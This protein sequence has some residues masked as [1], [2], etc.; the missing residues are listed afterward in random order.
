[1]NVKYSLLIHQDLTNGLLRK[2]IHFI[3]GN[4][5]I[6]L[7][8]TLWISIIRTALISIDNQIYVY[9]GYDINSQ[10]SYLK[11]VALFE[12]DEWSKLPDLIQ[13]RRG[14]NA[15]PFDSDILVV[16]GEGTMYVTRI[17]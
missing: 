8:L 7:T 15:I 11:T 10:N 1:M 16:G 14:Q 3:Q 9:G 5:V 17:Y 2:D 6:I 13:S 4:I 12:S